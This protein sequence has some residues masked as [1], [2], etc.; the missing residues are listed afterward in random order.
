MKKCNFVVQ[1]YNELETGKLFR[2]LRSVEKDLTEGKKHIVTL[3][4]LKAEDQ[5]IVNKICIILQMILIWLY[6][7]KLKILLE[8]VMLCLTGIILVLGI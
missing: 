7:W 8:I 5:F 2:S 1:H 4:A 3:E 6:H